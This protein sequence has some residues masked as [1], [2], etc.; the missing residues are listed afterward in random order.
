MCPADRNYNLKIR[1][2]ETQI[3]FPF[4]RPSFS[5][6]YMGTMGIRSSH[7]CIVRI[8]FH[9]IGCCTG[10]VR[11]QSR[12]RRSTNQSNRNCKAN[13]RVQRSRRR[14]DYKN[15]RQNLVCMCTSHCPIGIDN[16]PFRS[17]YIR[18]G[19][20][21]DSRNDHT[22]MSDSRAL[23]IQGDIHNVPFPLH[24][25][26]SRKSSH[27][28]MLKMYKTNLFAKCFSTILLRENFLTSANISFVPVF[29]S[30]TIEF[31]LTLV[32]VDA[33]GVVLTILANAAT[34]KTTTYIERK[35]LIIN[36]FI[37]D[38]SV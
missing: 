28:Y 14:I 6:T 30:W 21:L 1:K 29:A 2:K 37:V 15:V 35:T 17:N 19:D 8:V 16:H 18:M 34:I 33:F 23:E 38:A 10:I 9:R 13:S 22:N 27:N 11:S 5:T 25:C 31:R 32:A 12:K 20:N 36:F 3:N 7:L 26:R 24:S 4:S